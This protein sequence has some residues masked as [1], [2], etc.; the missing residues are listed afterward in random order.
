ML[1]NVFRVDCFHTQ[2]LYLRE[3]L[4]ILNESNLWVINLFG[5]NGNWEELLNEDHKLVTLST[6]MSSLKIH[7]KALNIVF[8]IQ[9]IF[10]KISRYAI[11]KRKLSNDN[12]FH[13]EYRLPKFRLRPDLPINVIELKKSK[14]LPT[15]G[16]RYCITL[17]AMTSGTGMCLLTLP[18]DD[19]IKGRSNFGKVDLFIY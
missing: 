11:S 4:Q 9:D 5:M 18:S 3:I 13:R 8:S 7:T 1:I 16:P 17:P 6:R 15:A 2:N 14:G 10:Q 19:K 12:N